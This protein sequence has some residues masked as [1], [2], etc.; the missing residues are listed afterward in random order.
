MEEILSSRDQDHSPGLDCQEGTVN[1]EE[2]LSSRDQDH[3][4]GQDWQVGTVNMDEVLS[5]RDQDH[6]PDQDCQGP[7]KSTDVRLRQLKRRSTSIHPATV[8]KVVKT[9]V[10]IIV[11]S[12]PL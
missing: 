7:F 4:P 6:S 5:S 11:L 3:S 9:K 10:I 8:N 2:I 12:S 1:M